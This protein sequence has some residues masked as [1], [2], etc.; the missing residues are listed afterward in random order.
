MGQGEYQLIS[1]P[2]LS[3]DVHYFGCG[4]RPDI[5]ATSQFPKG[6]YMGALAVKIGSK[7]IEIVANDLSVVGGESYQ[8]DWHNDKPLGPCAAAAFCRAASRVFSAL[9]CT[10]SFLSP[11]GRGHLGLSRG[12]APPLWC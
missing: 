6:T 10:Q 4:L 5:A 12:R 8:V 7:Q 9:F 2:A 1:V 3:A 11:G